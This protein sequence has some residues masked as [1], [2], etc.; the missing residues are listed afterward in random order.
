MTSQLLSTRP[1]GLAL[2]LVLALIAASCAGSTR[3]VIVK[4]DPATIPADQTVPCP[5]PVQLPD[6]DLTQGEIGRLWGADRLALDAC[7]QRH[8]ALVESVG[9]QQ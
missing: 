3:S 9:V 1:I 6:R 5:S 8:D 7:G 4:I 2:A